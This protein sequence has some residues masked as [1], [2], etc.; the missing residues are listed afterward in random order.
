MRTCLIP[1]SV[2]LITATPLAA[3]SEAA[4]KQQ[5]EGRTV[6][7]KVTIPEGL[8]SL[9]LRPDGAVLA[10]GDRT[11]TVTLLDTRSLTVVSRFSRS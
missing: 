2:L 11:G 6:T 7:Y 5:F 9:A 8:T 1:M 10:L 4:L 3:Q